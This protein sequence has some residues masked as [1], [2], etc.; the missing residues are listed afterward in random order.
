M[1]YL[2][3]FCNGGVRM[4]LI[5]TC[6]LIA[7]AGTS[8]GSSMEGVVSQRACSWGVELG[9]LEIVWLGVVIFFFFM[10]LVICP[11]GDMVTVFVRKFVNRDLVDVIMG[12]LC[13]SL[14]DECK[15]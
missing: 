14:T 7:R 8:V 13:G 11:W 1:V 3:Y 2:D 6:F 10:L 12:G 4:L 15:C 5:H 9:H